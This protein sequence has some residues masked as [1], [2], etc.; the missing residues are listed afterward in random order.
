MLFGYPGGTVLDIFNCLYDAPFKFIL[1]RHEQGAVHMA[2][3][4]ARATG[5]PDV[6]L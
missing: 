1:T 5:N 6:V 4:Y 2:D 3:G